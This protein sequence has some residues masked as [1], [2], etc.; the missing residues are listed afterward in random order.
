[1]NDNIGPVNLRAEDEASEL[2]KEVTT[3]L[4][5]RNDLLKAIEE[6]DPKEFGLRELFKNMVDQST[7]QRQE[8]DVLLARLG[9]E[10]VEW[11]NSFMSEMHKFWMD[12]KTAMSTNDSKAILS[13]C[14]FG[15]GVII[16]AYTQTLET[17]NLDN[18]ITV[19]LSRQLKE[20]E[21]AKKS[22]E[23]KLE[24]VDA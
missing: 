18:S 5:E 15:E 10:K 2:E 11:E 19:T 7:I 17:A 1:M 16:G 24:L 23:R 12:L 20:L 3:L 13:S 14:E 22:I 4:N 6:L 8:L 9:E 21:N